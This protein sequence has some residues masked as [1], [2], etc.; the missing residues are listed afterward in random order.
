MIEVMNE[1][2][3]F[4]FFG[5]FSIAGVFSLLAVFLPGLI[6]F[7][8]NLRNGKQKHWPVKHIVGTI[9]SGVIMT[10]GIIAAGIFFS[11]TAYYI[12]L[13]MPTDG[14]SSSSIS[15]LLPLLVA[16]INPLL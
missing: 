1:L 10:S 4:I 11:L 3:L 13:H 9:I 15:A 12:A 7:I 14:S 5:G 2:F 16:F 8:Y 6:V